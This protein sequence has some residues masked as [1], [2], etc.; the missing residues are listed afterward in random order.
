MTNGTS[1]GL[2]IIVAVVI[3]GI[4]TLISYLIFQS[5]LK[6]K[7]MNIFETSFQQVNQNNFYNRNLLTNFDEA[8]WDKYKIGVASFS[9][10]DNVL[11]L[12]NN[13]ENMFGFN[14]ILSKKYPEIN[15]KKGTLVTISFQAKGIGRLQT[16]LE[17]S[18]LK[19]FDI[20]SETFLDFT[21][22]FY[23]PLDYKQLVEKDL[24]R[25]FILYSHSGSDIY[26]KNASFVIGDFK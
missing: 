23:Q 19:N 9:I 2:F 5:S 3:F 20:D 8:T 21:F 10:N 22:S 15:I 24:I 25:A 6:P 4:F 18:Y 17:N 14:F 7:L 1:Q 12:V 16:G 11:H 26:I 13:S